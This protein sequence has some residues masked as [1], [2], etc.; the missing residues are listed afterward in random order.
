MAKKQN[1]KAKAKIAKVKKLDVAPKTRVDWSKAPKDFLVSIRELLWNEIL[2]AI[3]KK[4]GV[5]PSK[6]A[7]Q[8]AFLKARVGLPYHMENRPVNVS[9]GLD[10]NGKSVKK[11][12]ETEIKILAALA[13]AQDG[14]QFSDLAAKA[15]LSKRSVS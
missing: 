1:K 14:L 3:E 12:K 5:R 10:K 6:K 4:T 11:L 7:A 13:E 15:G 8:A 9:V 2:D